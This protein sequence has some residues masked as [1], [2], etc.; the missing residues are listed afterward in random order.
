[1][2]P[3]RS[4]LLEMG[5]LKDILHTHC[6]R[7]KFFKVIVEEPHKDQYIQAYGIN[8]KTIQ[9]IYLH[10]C[11]YMFRI[12]ALNFLVKILVVLLS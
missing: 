10:L 6:L 9:Y 11:I 4:Y 3:C 7:G 12:F 2:H 1:M 5:C 8:L